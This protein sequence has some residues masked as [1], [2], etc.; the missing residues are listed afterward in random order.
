MNPDDKDYD[1]W[2]EYTSM[3]ENAAT[4]DYDYLGRWQVK[5][6]HRSSWARYVVR[7][8]EGEAESEKIF[9]AQSAAQTYCEQKLRE[10]TCAH[11][12]EQPVDD[13]DVPF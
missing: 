5:R 8:V 3:A 12:I 9:Y 4:E 10:G 6:P 2:E 13:D 7:T 11:V 1:K